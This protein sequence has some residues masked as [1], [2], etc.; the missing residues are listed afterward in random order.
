M[1]LIVGRDVFGEK[2]IYY[3]IGRKSAFLASDL[4]AF[5]AMPQVQLEINRKAAA[6][7]VQYGYI[8]EPQTIYKNILK[9]P[10][11]HFATLKVDNATLGFNLK[12]Y[13]QTGSVAV[14]KSI[15]VNTRTLTAM[16]DH[17]ISQASIADVPLGVFLSGGIDSSIVTAILAQKK[18]QE[19]RTFTVRFPNEGFD[20]S[21]KA[22][23]IANFFG[24]NHTTIDLTQQEFLNAVEALPHQFSEPFADPSSIPT[25]IMCQR[26]Q[27]HLK[28]ALTGDGGDELFMGYNRHFRGIYLWKRLN[29]LPEPMRLMLLRLL[30]GPIGHLAQQSLKTSI[31][32]LPESGKQNNI[33]YKIKKA[34]YMLCAKDTDELFQRLILSGPSRKQPIKGYAGTGIVPKKIDGSLDIGQAFAL[35]DQKNYLPSNVLVKSDRCGMANGLE[36]RA[37]LLSSSVRDFANSLPISQKVHRGQGKYIL[38][39]VLKQHIP[40]KL[41]QFPKSGFDVPLETWMRHDLHELIND[42]LSSTNLDMHG[43][44]EPKIVEDQL[45]GFNKGKTESVQWIWNVFNLQRWKEEWR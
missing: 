20:E 14:D 44:L 22:S 8:P 37:P 13:D 9:L 29:E 23:R 11:G 2:P 39:K 19:L 33:S 3:G 21:K 25:M 5:D 43:L 26:T 15:E 35:L 16:L 10:P 34:Q 24:T 40:K 27:H 36:I 42:T 30:Q 1:I 41:Y 45:I 28:V 4:A 12:S 6:Q 7:F 18:S 17:S 31:K 38:K 32:M